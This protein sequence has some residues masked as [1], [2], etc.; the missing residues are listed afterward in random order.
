M[1]IYY[2]EITVS[3]TE[4]TE[5]GYGE[6]W[7][8]PIGTSEYIA[9][10]WLDEWVVLVGGG[11]YVAETTPDKHYLNVIVQEELPDDAIQTGWIW[12]K[13]SVKQAYLY[14]FGQYILI[15]GA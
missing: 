4:P 3:I 10:I 6:I 2:R 7:I 5:Q 11:V 14:L 15:A 1:A 9:Y 13:E 12:C 8:N